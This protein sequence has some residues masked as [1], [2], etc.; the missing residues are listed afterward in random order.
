M[1]LSEIIMHVLD[2]IVPPR[3]TDKVVRTLTL[4]ELYA[5][6]LRGDKSGSLPYHDPRVRALVWELKYFAHRRAAELAGAV[7]A[8]VLAGIAS[9]TL[10]KP[11]LIPVPM[12]AAR[13]RERGHNQTEVLCKAALQHIESF[14]DYA[15]HTLVRIQATPQQQGLTNMNVNII[16]HTQ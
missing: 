14:F 13:R 7:L 12:H 3:A 8:D 6:T 1:K 5:I 2:S 11:L 16:L 10:G 15:P 4:D 9:E